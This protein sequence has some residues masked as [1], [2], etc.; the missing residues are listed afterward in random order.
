MRGGITQPLTVAVGTM[1]TVGSSEPTGAVPPAI[2]FA[3]AASTLVIITPQIGYLPALYA[4]YSRGK[5]R[6]RC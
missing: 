1:T 3:A 4:A 2:V 6:W 5:P